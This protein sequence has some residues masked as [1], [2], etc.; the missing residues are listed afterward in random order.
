MIMASRSLESFGC[1]RL[2][3]LESAEADGETAANVDGA[4]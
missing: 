4:K 3:G 1:C 2:V